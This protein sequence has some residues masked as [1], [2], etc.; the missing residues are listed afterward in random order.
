M[1]SNGP[2]GPPHRLTYRSAI[3]DSGAQRKPSVVNCFD[4]MENAIPLGTHG[5]SDQNTSIFF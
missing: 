4:A 3:I 2:V 5:R 1:S